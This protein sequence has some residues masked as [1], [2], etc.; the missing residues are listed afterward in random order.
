MS[1]DYCKTA[2]NKLTDAWNMFMDT[3]QVQKGILRPDSYTSWIRC[4]HKK[5]YGP[6]VAL[7]EEAF[8]R[9]QE[10]NRSLINN[11]K[12]VM[13]RVD[14]ILKQKIDSSY[15]LILMDAEGLIVDV[16][17]HGSN[18]IPLGTRYH[19]MLACSNAIDISSQE[20][21]MVEVYGYEHL[22]PQASEWN[23]IG[24]RI[25]NYDKSVAG[26]FG[27]VSGISNVSALVPI[28][29]IG[30]Q[31]VQSG[32]VFEQIAVNKIGLLLEEIPEA[33]IAIN[34]LGEILSA[35]Q[36][37]L[38]LLNI[39]QE[40]LIGKNIRDYLLGDID[41]Y[42]L[43]TCIDE[44]N[45][46]NNI[47]IRGHQK[48]NYTIVKK[49]FIDKFYH[50]SLITLSFK[51]NLPKKIGSLSSQPNDNLHRFE[52]LIGDTV[53]IKLVK[54][55]AQKT[56]RSFFNVLIEGESGTGK[57]LLAQSI[58]MSSRPQGP[59]VA[60]NC[61]ALTRELL[62][63]ELFGYEEG[64]FTGAIKGGKPGKFEL[65]DGGSIF[66]DEIGEMPIEMQVSLLRCLQ[67]KTVT[68]V[69]GSQPKK[70]DI[71]IIAATNRNLYEQVRNG[72]FRE[73]L[74]YRL[75]VIEI[76]MP[77][78]RER[79]ADI[80]LLCNHIL[81]ELSHKLDLIENVQISPAAMDCLCHYHWPGNVRELQNVLERAVIYSDGNLIDFE[82]LPL[83]I[84]DSSPQTADT[85]GSLKDFERLAIIEAVSKHHGNISKSAAELGIAR[86]T[87]YQKMDRLGISPHTLRK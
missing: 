12:P 76:K 51:K 78:L 80:P 22:Y 53:P 38:Q 4:D 87:L 26:A 66:L 67:D 52:D 69:G 41:Y 42:K 71:R 37:F 44:V 39:S 25:L 74:Y 34:H 1:Y 5:I 30:S 75:N 10:D 86:S 21:K 40:R 77:P 8:A 33:V 81:N 18:D 24:D 56:A 17:Y 50:H 58:H 57:E 83:P 59:F 16:V 32:L 36:E 79:I 27:I 19:E 7:S 68:R 20:R 15:A 29:K 72:N 3:G 73:D 63:S 28:V 55:I 47:S 6:L 49:S 70:I 13:Q 65:A 62:Q 85:N 43:F 45:I 82:C 54:T 48:N 35:N 31:L 61:G 9:K 2:Y 64:A 23:T 60:I 46:F 11:Y 84:R 14:S